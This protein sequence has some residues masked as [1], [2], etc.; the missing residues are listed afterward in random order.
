MSALEGGRL[1]R[2]QRTAGYLDVLLN[3]LTFFLY[4]L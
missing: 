2:L 1:V 3:I 4:L